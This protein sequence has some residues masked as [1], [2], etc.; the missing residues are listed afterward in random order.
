MVRTFFFLG[1]LTLCPGSSAHAEAPVKVFARAVDAD[2]ILIVTGRLQVIPKAAAKQAK[3]ARRDPFEEV[4]V[5][6]VTERVLFGAPPPKVIPFAE[7]WYRLERLEQLQK[8]THIFV[9]TTSNEP[10]LYECDDQ[11]EDVYPLTELKAFE[12]LAQAHLDCLVLGS[13]Q[14][15]IGKSAGDEVV[16]KRNLYGSAKANDRLRLEPPDRPVPYQRGGTYV[17]FVSIDDDPFGDAPD[18]KSKKLEV[19]TRWPESL[20]PLVVESL[21]RREKHPIYTARADEGAV[22]EVVFLGP[23]AEAFE[24]MQSTVEDAALLGRQRLAH[25]GR[26]AFDGVV[27]AIEANLFREKLSSANAFVYQ[28][29]L[30]AL[31]A[32]SDPPGAK[33]EIARLIEKMLLAAEAGETFPVPPKNEDANHDLPFRR[34]SR[35]G[36]INPRHNHSLFWLLRTLKDTDAAAKYGQRLMKLRDLAQYG[37]KDEANAVLSVGH[38]EDHLEYA[39]VEAKCQSLRPL[40]WQAGFRGD[41][42]D[43]ATLAFS[44]T[45]Q[46]LAAGRFD[47][48][49]VW[50][51]ADWSLV[52]DLPVNRVDSLAFST[53]GK[54]LFIGGYDGLHSWDWTKN[55]LIDSYGTEKVSRV[56]VAGSRLYA[57]NFSY[58][59]AEAKAFLWDLASAKLLQQFPGETWD[60]VRLSCDGQKLLVKDSRDVWHHGPAHSKTRQ[61]LPFTA[62][63]MAWTADGQRWWT[64]EKSDRPAKPAPRDEERLFAPPLAKQWKSEL[65]QREAGGNYA[66]VFEK[67]LEFP[68]DVLQVAGDRKSICVRYGEQVE[69]LTSPNW[70]SVGKWRIPKINKRSGLNDASIF[71]FDEATIQN[72]QLSPDG[73]F[74]AVSR[75]YSYPAV[76]DARTGVPIE[77]SEGHSRE[78]VELTFKANDQEIATAGMD[79]T[80]CRWNATTG[81]RIERVRAEVKPREDERGEKYLFTAEDGQVWFF[82]GDRHNG[83]KHRST[84]FDIRLLPR[85]AKLAEDFDRDNAPGKSLGVIEP[86]SGD[87]DERGLVSGGKYLHFGTSIYRRKDLKPMSTVHHSGDMDHMVFSADGERYALVTSKYDEAAQKHRVRL[88]VHDTATGKMDLAVTLQARIR[89]LTFSKDGQRLATI[90][91]LQQLAVWPM[92]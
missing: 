6:L 50:K 1:L 48:C 27:A 91:E 79:G 20:A 26:A 7:P 69:I 87:Y 73:Q 31:A 11:D 80:R 54:Q 62:V 28:R 86:E 61:K 51:T 60:E 2:E 21:G 59:P 83:Y 4:N 70:K 43:D 9:L 71:G 12:A 68:A 37:W 72:C 88:R 84:V 77:L 5:Q 67:Q 90:D 16:V 63:D 56:Y 41:D 81:K 24:L 45:G 46:Y 38:L 74:L 8:E 40:T 53:D 23:R 66:V 42:L 34:R 64:L 15:F 36:E 22:Q 39:E 49:R 18:G 35:Y 13:Q 52:A 32:E 85:G 3:P 14:V 44:A 30:I 33:T 47:T 17:Y 78:I 92:P 89:L 75:E 65:R 19:I 58:Q 55:K 29:E 25:D 82:Y 76:Y 57:V 10:L